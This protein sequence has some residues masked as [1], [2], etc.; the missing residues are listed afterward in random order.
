M[1]ILL[2]SLLYDYGNPE[3]GYSY[4]YYNFYL[5]LKAIYGNT[6]F[7]DVPT[8][9]TNMGKE[10]MNA[11][12]LNKIQTNKYDL[13]IFTPYMDEFIPEI[14]SQINKH[15]KTLA[16]F[17]DDTWRREHT[18][19]WGK[20]FNYFTTTDI[21]GEKYYSKLGLNNV[22]YLPGGCNKDI[23]KK[24]DLPYLYDVSFVGGWHPVR[25]WL[26]NSLQKEGI[27][28]AAFGARWP[29]GRVEQ[30]K[31]IQIF[32]QSK[33][34]LNLSN[35]SSWDIRYLLSNL[36]AIINTIRSPKNIEQIKGRHFEINGCGSFQLSYYV[37]GLE[38]N[39]EIGKEIAIYTSPEDLIEKI[40]YYLKYEDEREEIAKAGYKRTLKN[41]TFDA[42][43]DN[44]FKQ[45]L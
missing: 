43:F 8:E 14:I 6:E 30:D 28:V 16:I 37:E 34:N 21:Y 33:I 10:K 7:Y 1:N 45:I 38:H 40:K 27:K 22:I 41:H 44:I 17:S 13:I 39:Y 18:Q 23:Y 24:L 32:N 36:R 4:N 20:Y 3:R 11:D 42:I 29:N 12:L 25:Q 35:S 15:T 9:L 2:A 5:T 31:M 19:Y 26:I